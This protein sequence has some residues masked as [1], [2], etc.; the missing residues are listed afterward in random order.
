MLHSIGEKLSAG[1]KNIEARLHAPAAA[2]GAAPT[3]A[4]AGGLAGGVALVQRYVDALNQKTFTQGVYDALFAPGVTVNGAHLD[5]TRPITGVAALLAFD[6][7]LLTKTFPDGRFTLTCPVTVDNAGWVH[8]AYSFEGT[9]R[10]PF[11]SSGA[12]APTNRAGCMA[13]CA[14]YKLDAA[15]S[16]IE[17]AYF[18]NDHYTLLTSLGLVAPLGGGG[19]V[20]AVAPCCG[21]AAAGKSQAAGGGAVG[22]PTGMAAPYTVGG[23][24]QQQPTTAAASTMDAQ[25]RQ[26]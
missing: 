24:Q 8:V 2:G 19:N 1:A 16:K 10:A 22:Q 14:K 20:A 6:E 15:G 21:V 7:A 25:A 9:M 17:S 12:G 13:G 4:W 11:P 3:A 5:A 18:T 23:Q 26:R